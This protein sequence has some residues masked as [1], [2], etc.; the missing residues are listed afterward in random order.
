LLI[1]ILIMQM[2][3]FGVQ[4][5]ADQPLLLDQTAVSVQKFASCFMSTQQD[6]SRPV[7]AVLHQDGIR[8]SNAGAP[9]VSN[10]YSIRVK[11]DKMGSRL[12]VFMSFRDKAEEKTLLQSISRCS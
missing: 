1:P 9:Q 10:P 7:W 2:T 11:E 8:I 4:A 5:A 12:A 3:A 6:Q